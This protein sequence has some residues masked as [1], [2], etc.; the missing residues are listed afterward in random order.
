MSK[1]S[2]ASSAAMAAFSITSAANEGRTLNL[3]FPDGTATGEHLTVLGS[4]SK[5]FRAGKS[6]FQ[7]Q[8]LALIK[9]KEKIT[10]EEYAERE[11]R[12]TTTLLS[13]CVVGWSFDVPFSRKGVLE[14]LETAPYLEPALDSFLVDRSNFFV[15]PQKAS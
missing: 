9:E 5:A 15:T 14:F 8:S 7:R 3:E 1:T 2:P 4:D 10:V 6:V 13:S 12:L 11:A